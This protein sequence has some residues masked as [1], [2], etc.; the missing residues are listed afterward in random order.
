MCQKR[1]RGEMGFS[2]HARLDTH[3]EQIRGSGQANSMARHLTEKHPA[4]RR[5]PITFSFQVEK[6]GEQPLLRQIRE[7]QKIANET[8][9]RLINGRNKHIPPA[10]RPLA[11]GHQ[12]RRRKMTITAELSEF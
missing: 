4:R 7:A 11:P 5:D 6:A 2:S 3:K 9:G 12:E 1:Y 10:I 8:P